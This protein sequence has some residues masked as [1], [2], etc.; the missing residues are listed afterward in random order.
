M[1]R[2]CSQLIALIILTAGISLGTAHTTISFAPTLEKVK[3]AL[4]I[5]KSSSQMRDIFP[6]PFNRQFGIPFRERFRSFFPEEPLEPG[7]NKDT[8][9]ICVTEERHCITYMPRAK[10]GDSL[11]IL[12]PNSSQPKTTKVIAVDRDSGIALLDCRDECGS[13]TVPLGTLEDVRAGDL[14]LIIG[15]ENEKIV[16]QIGL[17]AS[18]DDDEVIITASQSVSGDLVITGE[19]QFL[20]ILSKTE[21]GRT[22]KLIPPKTIAQFLEPETRVKEKTGYL[23]VIIQELSPD[24]KEFLKIRGTGVVVAEVLPGSPAEKAGLQPGDV[25]THFKG[26]PVVSPEQFKREVRSTP[27][28]SSVTMQIDREGRR[29]TIKTI[30]EPLP[31]TASSR[32]PSDKPS[33]TQTPEDLGIIV[34]ELNDVLRHK[35]GIPISVKGLIITGVNPRSIGWR[36]GLKPGDVIL[37]ANKK[38]TKTPQDLEE[39]IKQSES[40][41]LIRVWSKGAAKFLVIPL[42]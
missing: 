21:Q 32:I 41:L 25:I 39:A 13:K 12:I 23:G 24:L 26:R 38:P 10:E 9:A 37:E 19:G 20:G 17:V 1:K 15:T 18:V 5:A 3:G 16:P 35:Y 2:L 36:A 34:E 11:Q 40:K 30:I 7:Q 4:L 29:L 8:L 27:P 31:R 22:Y 28:G 6:Q 42:K 14:V 33:I